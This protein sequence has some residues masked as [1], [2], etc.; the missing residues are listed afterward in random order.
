MCHAVGADADS[1]G[2]GFATSTGQLAVLVVV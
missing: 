2:K 1:A